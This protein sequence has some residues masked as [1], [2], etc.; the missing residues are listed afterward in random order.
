MKQPT[1]QWCSTASI[2]AGAL[3]LLL[4]PLQFSMQHFVAACMLQAHPG[5]KAPQSISE[6][7][8]TRRYEWQIKHV[9]AYLDSLGDERLILIVGINYI[10]R[11]KTVKNLHAA[12]VLLCSWGC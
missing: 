9:Q 11:A 10:D 8:Y 4:S 5:S 2:Q 6:L 7:Y 12:T 1:H 3:S